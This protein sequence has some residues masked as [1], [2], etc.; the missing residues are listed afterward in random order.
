MLNVFCFA[1]GVYGAAKPYQLQALIGPSVAGKSTLLDMLAMRT[2]HSM[3]AASKVQG[4][5][6][7]NGRRR[8]TGFLKYSAYVPQV[9]FDELCTAST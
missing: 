6:L 7:V 4:V 5:V 2:H 8:T 3:M 1:Q 9:W